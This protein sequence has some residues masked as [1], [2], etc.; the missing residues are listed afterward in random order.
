MINRTNLSRDDPGSAVRGF[1]RHWPTAFGEVP[2]PRS[3]GPSPSAHARP[4]SHCGRPSKRVGTLDGPPERAD[5]AARSPGVPVVRRRVTAWTTVRPPWREGE[6]RTRRTLAAARLRDCARERP[7]FNPPR[8]G[9]RSQL[10][11]E[12]VART[13]SSEACFERSG[14]ILG[15]GMFLELVFVIALFQISR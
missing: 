8:E 9:P 11:E 6:Y 10:T 13:E 14:A 1:L 15:G 5:A 4:R 3:D 2:T 12:L 7:N